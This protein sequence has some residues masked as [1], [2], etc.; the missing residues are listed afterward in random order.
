MGEYVSDNQSIQGGRGERSVSTRLGVLLENSLHTHSILSLHI[1]K[2]M[3][4]AELQLDYM[5]A[6]YETT[7]QLD[8]NDTIVYNV[9]A[10]RRIYTVCTMMYCT[11]R[12]CVIYCV[13]AMCINLHYQFS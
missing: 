8:R 3:G 2:G 11:V 6:V 4:D 12:D 5:N 1:V 9:Y 7:Y 10:A 13:G